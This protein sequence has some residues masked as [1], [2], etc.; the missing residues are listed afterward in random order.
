MRESFTWIEYFIAF[1][2][3]VLQQI[4]LFFKIVPVQSF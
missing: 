1:K 2:V 3:K 4:K